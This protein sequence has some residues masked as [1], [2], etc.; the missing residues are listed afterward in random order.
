MI[1]PGNVNSNGETLTEFAFPALDVNSFQE[2]AEPSPF[3]GGPIRHSK[4]RNHTNT[5]YTR[6][7]NSANSSSQ[8]THWLSNIISKFLPGWLK[9]FIWP[10]TTQRVATEDTSVASSSNLIETEN[11]VQSSIDELHGTIVEREENHLQSSQ[12]NAVS[13]SS[14]KVKYSR[15][16]SSRGTAVFGGRIKSSSAQRRGTI[17]RARPNH[18]SAREEDLLYP[19]EMKDS[20]PIKNELSEIPSDWYKPFK[21]L[22]VNDSFSSF[23]S[24]T[25]SSSKKETHAIKKPSSKGPP[26]KKFKT[27]LVPDAHWFDYYP[28]EKSN[29]EKKSTLVSKSLTSKK[30]PING[31]VPIQTQNP[32]VSTVST[33]STSDSGRKFALEMS[34]TQ[35]KNSFSSTPNSENKTP[36]D[37]IKK[38]S[39]SAVIE[40]TLNSGNQLA[41]VDQTKKIS[42]SITSTSS[43]SDFG[44]GF[45][46]GISVDQTKKSLTSTSAASNKSDP[47]FGSNIE[48]ET[49]NDQTKK[50]LI[51]DNLE[52]PTS[53][54]G[55]KITFGVIDG[56]T[57]EAS[58]TPTNPAVGFGSKFTFGISGDQTKQPSA[59]SASDLGNKFTFGIVNDQPKEPLVASTTSG[60]ASDQTKEPLVAS[61]KSAPDFGGKFTF[62]I[63]SDQTKELSA[64]SIKPASDLGKKF[65]FGMT[66][67]QSKEPSTASTK[68]ALTSDQTKELSAVSTEPAS[69][70]GDSL[71]FGTTSDQTKQLSVASTK[72]AS[73]FGGNITFEKYNEQTKKPSISA[74][75]NDATSNKLTFGMLASTKPASNFGKNFTFGTPDGQKEKPLDSSTSTKTSPNFGALFTPDKKSLN[76]STPTK[77]VFNLEPSA[78]IKPI[79]GTSSSQALNA[80]T[81]S[82]STKSHFD[83]GNSPAKSNISSDVPH[84]SSA[85]KIVSNNEGQMANEKEESFKTS[86][87]ETPIKSKSDETSTGPK[88]IEPKRDETSLESN[89]DETFLQSKKDN[90]KSESKNDETLLESKK[91]GTAPESK[92]DDTVLEPKKDD[93]V[94]E[95]K[96]DDTVPESKK[97]GALDP[98]NLPSILTSNSKETIGDIKDKSS[99]FAPNSSHTQTLVPSPSSG[100][101]MDIDTSNVNHQASIPQSLSFTSTSFDYSNFGQD[102]GKSFSFN[103]GGQIFNFNS[104]DMSSTDAQSSY[105][106]KHRQF[107]PRKQRNKRSY[108]PSGNEGRNI[109]LNPKTDSSDGHSSNR[110]MMSE[111]GA[112]TFQMDSQKS[113]LPTIPTQPISSTGS[114]FKFD[115]PESQKN[116]GNPFQ[117]TPISQPSLQGSNLTTFKFQDPQSNFMPQVPS[118]TSIFT[119]F[120]GNGGT[121]GF[122]APQSLIFDANA[123]S[124][125]SGSSTPTNINMNSGVGQLFSQQNQQNQPNRVLARMRKPKRK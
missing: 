80:T 56:Q 104:G 58:V 17:T 25:S 50:P 120:N 22:T 89:K 48:F 35:A 86:S 59:K 37:Q 87:S 14:L 84:S 95:S 91:D 108:E 23:T 113:D 33:K 65:T 98:S 123:N 57:K 43:T 76:F 72:P 54:S 107:I 71:T 61:T 6:F 102:L 21:D 1:E 83:F 4:K 122:N 81:T 110:M 27:N 20:L 13:R 90:G 97:D 32:S 30:Q 77:S 7:T 28:S 124:A 112:F 118:S 92:K 101:P 11:I 5:P 24:D 16:G 88:E 111:P 8:P 67:D 78:S 2:S 64:T 12:L 74:T 106:S 40:P 60:M 45:L 103:S 63:S 73:D 125:G 39:T 100:S 82:I 34:G 38:S 31:T 79:F 105:G 15:L 114:I 99:P 47:D 109:L 69:D 3:S 26:L 44:N 36:D 53:N 62:G 46:L 121:S 116:S 18:I 75:S 85:P 52:E 115:I 42:T 29:S 49:L 70:L 55:S 94:L 96:K 51:S 68:S 93:A 119:P 9:D 41:S 19:G 10:Q 66:G 117:T